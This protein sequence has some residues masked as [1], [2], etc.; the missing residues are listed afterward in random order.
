MASLV[1]SLIGEYRVTSL[2]G[3]GGMG[4]VY[5]A[6]HTHFGRL[7]AIKA[8]L[9]GQ[10]DSSTL[11]RFYG[12]ASIQASL[13]HP[14]VAEYLGFYEYQ[15]RPCILMEYVNGDTIS[16]IL[17][18]RGVFTPKDAAVILRAV[19]EVVAHFHSLGVVHR[20]IKS[21]NV[22]VNSSG[23]VK[24]LDF[25]I[26]RFQSTTFTTTGM[27]IG[28]P[29]VLAPEQMRGKTATQATDVWQLG[30]LAYEMLTGQLPFEAGSLPELY[31]QILNAS[32]AP[33]SPSSRVP[34]RL[35]KIVDRCLQKDPDRRFA[36]GN[37]LLIALDGLESGNPIL[38]EEN[39][40]TRLGKKPGA[41]STIIGARGAILVLALL[42]LVA[43]GWRLYS[44]SASVPTAEA[45]ISDGSTLKTVMVDTSN[46]IAEVFRHGQPVGQTPYEL[47]LRSGDKVDLLLHR[48]GYKDLPVQF[49]VTERKMYT[50]TLESLGE[51]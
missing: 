10:T 14:G 17:D 29:A 48:E 51:R 36:S 25:G 3:T 39:R 1:N 8:L 46:G 15:G 34:S 32:Y 5:L 11:R 23:V 38:R 35:E 31:A 47:H 30:V 21:S 4:E 44:R 43:L 41:R 28:T 6:T 42:F 7:I 45:S 19:S 40:G 27:V 50:Y 49:E 33:I 18:R 20:D 13:R 16:T 24:V 37:D 26:A 2:L 12:E 9:P 22:K